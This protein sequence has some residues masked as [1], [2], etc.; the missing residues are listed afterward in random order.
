MG[1]FSSKKWVNFQQ[2]QH[3]TNGLFYVNNKPV[4]LSGIETKLM[5]LFITH[6]NHPLT[7][8]QI[9]NEVW[10][11]KNIST[12]NVRDTVSHLR[13]KLPDLNLQTNFGVGYSL[14]KC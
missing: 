4:F 6:L 14:I 11:E 10:N 9:K 2:K 8:K 13:K 7:I 1:H 3:L 5:D 12:T